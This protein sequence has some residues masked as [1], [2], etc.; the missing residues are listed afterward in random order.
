M[1]LQSTTPN[2]TDALPHLPPGGIVR[3]LGSPSWLVQVKQARP[4]VYTSFRFFIGDG[5]TAEGTWDECKD[6]WRRIYR[7]WVDKTYLEH[8]APYVDMVA[9][10]NEYA[11]TTTWQSTHDTHR[12]MQSLAAAVAVWEQEYRGRWVSSADGGYGFIP[13]HTRL[14]LLAQPVSNDVPAAVMQLALDTDNVV[15]YRAYAKCVAG[16][17]VPECWRE[18]SGRWHF[19]EQAAGLKPLWMFGECGPYF[20]TIEGWRHPWCLGGD[21]DKLYAVMRAFFRDVAGTDAFREGRLLGAH[22]CWY[23]TGDPGGTWKE[24]ELE[25]SQ[26]VRLAQIAREE[27]TPKEAPVT[28]AEKQQVAEHIHRAQA[29]LQAALRIVDPAA[30]TWWERLPEGTIPSLALRTLRPATMRHPD[31]RSRGFT[32]S[33]NMTA[34]ARS[35]RLLNVW[36]Q[37]GEVNDWWVDVADV[38]PA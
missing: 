31:G 13:A 28:D 1:H 19:M 3:A 37:P 20:H 25:A 22:G 23:S 14:C 33:N 34:V 29:E 5:Q 35:G 36:D 15:D 11:A 9:E 32:R 4:D 17:R 16:Q 12:V 26:L 21:V 24:Y 10:G 7:R 30:L 6:H 27:L 38:E 18:H 8:Y 2:W